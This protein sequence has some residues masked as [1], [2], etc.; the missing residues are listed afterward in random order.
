MSSHLAGLNIGHSSW[1]AHDQNNKH[2]NIQELRLQKVNN[3]ALVCRGITEQ[4]EKKE[5]SKNLPELKYER[6]SILGMKYNHD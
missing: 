2:R 6:I 3:M 5:E 4:L 1:Y